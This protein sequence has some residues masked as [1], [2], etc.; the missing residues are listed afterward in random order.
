MHII[1]ISSLENDL[2]TASRNEPRTES[3]KAILF[4]GR[5]HNKRP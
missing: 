3:E 2:T 4:L 5:G 1:I